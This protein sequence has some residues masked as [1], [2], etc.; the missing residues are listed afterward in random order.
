MF[1]KTNTSTDTNTT[2][3][4]IPQR[5]DQN[6]C[7]QSLQARDLTRPVPA[8]RGVRPH[9]ADLLSRMQR[10]AVYLSV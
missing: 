2:A 8:R 4:A 1:S 3:H 5:S 10:R 9:A 7:V 6:A